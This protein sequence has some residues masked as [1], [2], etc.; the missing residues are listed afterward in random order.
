MIENTVHDT[1]EVNW[2]N[3]SKKDLNF[4][5]SCYISAFHKL[6]NF[7]EETGML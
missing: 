4:R 2:E 7:Y 1:V 3:A 5:D 6:V